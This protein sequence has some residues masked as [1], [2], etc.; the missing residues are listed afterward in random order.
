MMD[1]RVILALGL[2]LFVLISFQLIM[3][4]YYP[5]RAGTG[6]GAR[7]IEPSLGSDKSDPYKA[8]VQW[9]SEPIQEEESPLEIQPILFDEKEIIFQNKLYTITF[10]DIGAGIKKIVLNKHPKAGLNISYEIFKAK[11][12]ADSMFLFLPDKIGAGF[13]NVKYDVRKSNEEVIFTHNF[14]N[15]L[16]LEKRFHFHN[17]LYCIELEI[18]FRN[19]KGADIAKNY[20]LVSNVHLPSLKSMDERFLEIAANIDGKVLKNKKSGRPFEVQRNGSLNWVMLK[21][22]YFSI[23]VRPFHQSFGYIVQQNKSGKLISALN[24]QSFNIPSNSNVTHK[25]GL[26]LGPSNFELAKEANI[27]VEGALSY[28]MLGSIGQLLM[29]VLKFFHSVSRNWGVSILLLTLFINIILF[30][31][32]RKSYKSMHEM[33]VLQPKIEK[34]RQEFKNNPQKLQKEIMELYKKH[35]VNPMGGCLP[36]LLQMPIFFAL[37]QG[38]INFV[39]LRGARFLWVNDLSVSEN[40]RLPVTLPLVGDSINILPILMVI[41]MFFQQRLSNKL[42]SLSQTDEQ[43]KQQRLM[44]VF[45]TVMFGF[46]FYNMPSGFVLYWLS[47]SIIMTAIQFMLTRRPRQVEEYA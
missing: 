15:E 12:P 16:L 8:A 1:K 2:S 19:L 24:V 39:E 21:N 14:N 28:G 6:V 29:S 47:S 35:K 33:Q 36:L 3:A 41:V 4:K 31:L 9:Q 7:F 17:S 40:I 26:Y 45:M 38:L 20:S 30:P 43:R 11:D 23:I 10:T 18:N 44:S 27:G 42:T 5:Q 13:N 22:R 25:Y 37:Y 32:T 34:L 46:I